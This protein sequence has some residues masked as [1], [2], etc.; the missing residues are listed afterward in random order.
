MSGAFHRPRIAAVHARNRDV[1]HQ[2]LDQM[3]ALVQSKGQP[4][5]IDELLESDTVLP[6]DTITVDEVEALLQH[7][8]LVGTVHAAG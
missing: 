3:I 1:V 6:H 5:S 7:E 8:S 4:L 2:L